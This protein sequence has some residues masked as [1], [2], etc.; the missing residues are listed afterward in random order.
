VKLIEKEKR[1]LK[2]IQRTMLLILKPFEMEEFD[3]SDIFKRVLFEEIMKVIF[4]PFSKI[5]FKKIRF[6]QKCKIT[7]LSI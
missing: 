2:R 3:N 5:D 6:M 7:L 4:F 1:M